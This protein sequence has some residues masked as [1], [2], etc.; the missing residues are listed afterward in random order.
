M[1]VTWDALPDAWMGAYTNQ[2]GM[3]CRV[4]QWVGARDMKL[5]LGVLVGRDDVMLPR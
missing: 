2:L 5:E 3:H 1:I 4:C